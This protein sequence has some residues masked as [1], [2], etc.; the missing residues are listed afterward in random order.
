MAT[1][2]IVDGR[3]LA[4]DGGSAGGF[5]TLACLTMRK[6]FRAGTSFYGVADL[7]ALAQDT[8]KFESRYLD[9]LVGPYP[10]CKN[11]YDERSPINNVDGL[12][13]PLLLLQGDEDMIVPMNQ[14]TTMKAACDAKKIPAP[15]SSSRRA[16]RVS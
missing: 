13:C 6:T 16:A 7:T 9:G 11:V 2:G 12:N 8:H 3:R 1:E 5:T 4:I 14:A 15:C 10:E